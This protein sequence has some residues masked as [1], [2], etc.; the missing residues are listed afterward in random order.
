[1]TRLFLPPEMWE[2]IWKTA[3]EVEASIRIVPVDYD[4]HVIPRKQL[5]SPLLSTCR[6]SRWY[7]LQFYSI[8]LPVY[9]LPKSNRD[10]DDYTHLTEINP[11]PCLIRKQFL[12]TWEAVLRR[13]EDVTTQGQLAGTVYLSPQYDTFLCGI[14]F[15]RYFLHDIHG[16][17]TAYVSGLMEGKD[18]DSVRNM[19]FAEAPFQQRPVRGVEKCRL[20]VAHALWGKAWFPFTKGWLHCW[21]PYREDVPRKL[22]PWLVFKAW[23]AEDFFEYMGP[24]DGMEK[25]QIRQWESGVD[26]QTGCDAV[27]GATWPES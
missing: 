19:V 16:V 26:L 4:A 18:R 27:F 7:A 12:Q 15:S 2:M 24:T 13:L 6:A 17:P 25:L 1:M 14:D 5:A 22:R 10:R 23:D 3:L 11:R 8:K 21:L 20:K 9:K